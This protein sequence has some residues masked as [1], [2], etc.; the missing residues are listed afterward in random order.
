MALKIM[1]E[2]FSAAPQ[3]AG[4]IRNIKAQNTKAKFI[5][6]PEKLIRTKYASGTSRFP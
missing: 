4:G 5:L 3:K 1:A 2:A 6:K